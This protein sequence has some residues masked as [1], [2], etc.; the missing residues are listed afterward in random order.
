[1]A[2]DNREPATVHRIIAAFSAATGALAAAAPA[3]LEIERWSVLVHEAMA[4]RTRLF[5]GPEHIFDVAAGAGADPVE[6]LASLFH[7]LVYVQVDGA[8]PP[9]VGELVAG[10]V[11]I[12]STGG[13]YRVRADAESAATADPI[14]H[15]VRQVFGL[16]AGQALSPFS[17][18]NEFLSAVV[19]G[20]ALAPLLGLE[21]TA[22]VAACIEGT[23]PFRG[24]DPFEQLAVRLGKLDGVALD[25]AA[26][27][28]AVRRAVRVANSDVGNFADPDVARFLDNTWRLLPET[29]PAL[30]VPAAYSIRQYRTALGKMEGFLASLRAEQV[31]HRWG[32][33]PDDASY[34]RL[35]ARTSANLGLAVRYLGVKLYAAAVL[36]GL[37]LASGGDAPLE[38]FAGA[39]PRPG[40]EVK[41][42]D[43]FLPAA[44]EAPRPEARVDPA[45][46]ALF[47]D[48]RAAESSFDLR[49]SPLSAFF[50][51]AL[52]EAGLP[53]ALAAARAFAAGGLGA[54][55]FLRGQPAPLVAAV[56]RAA[57]R[58][59]VTRSEGL[60]RLAA[61]R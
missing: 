47:V 12:E 7:D 1:V 56:A 23:I 43:K 9:R 33:E 8:L 6:T 28:A 26:V 21:V 14:G 15:L 20:R 37:A 38:L 25:E 41:R 13:G 32:G 4:A 2:T 39:I 3:P 36:E 58:V 27:A 42:I 30:L 22:A 49:T 10:V 16:A 55:D 19:A 34:A 44:P 60:E 31:F 57:A 11:E 24:G 17:G 59:A 35:L 45:L 5:H 52:G 29:N 51:R 40:T 46:L 50:Y 61:A 53:G 54:E 18:L 48:G